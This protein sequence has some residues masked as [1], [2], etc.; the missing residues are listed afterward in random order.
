MAIVTQKYVRKPIYVDAVEVTA[1]NFM[2]LAFWTTGKIESNDP[3]VPLAPGTPIDPETQHIK[4]PVT[5]ARNARQAQAHLGDWVL[6]TEHGL[7]VYTPES[8]EGAFD[9]WKEPEEIVA[10]EKP[11][12]PEAICDTCGAPKGLQVVGESCNNNCGGTVIVNPRAEPPEPGE[13]DE[14]EVEPE[15]A[16]EVAQ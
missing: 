14:S 16:V 13:D 8:F 2:E 7:K 11:Q 6:K 4:V 10:P 1:D 3:D 12:P 15:T 9:Q 5:N